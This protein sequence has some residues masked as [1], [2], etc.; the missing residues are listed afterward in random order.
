MQRAN[1]LAIN[2]VT[3]KFTMNLFHGRAREE[4]SLE[5]DEGISIVTS[6]ITAEGML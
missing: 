4:S 3:K 5:H 2:G 6:Q 1:L